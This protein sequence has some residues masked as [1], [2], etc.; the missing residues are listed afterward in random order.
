[1]FLL[2]KTSN[3]PCLSASLPTLYVVYKSLLFIFLLKCHWVLHRVISLTP[4]LK[5]HLSFYCLPSCFSHIYLF[6]AFSYALMFL[7]VIL[8]QLPLENQFQERLSYW[9]LYP[10][11]QEQG[12]TVATTTIKEKR[13]KEGR[14]KEK[15]WGWME[16]GR[17]RGRG[18]REG[19]GAEV[20]LRLQL[21]RCYRNLEICCYGDMKKTKATRHQ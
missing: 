4:N 2:P 13:K 12:L 9:P 6:L 17:E 18:G 5:C 10:Q 8:Y 7:Y 11:H 16:R 1:M 15:R 20:T 14:K 21:W 3:L 19:E